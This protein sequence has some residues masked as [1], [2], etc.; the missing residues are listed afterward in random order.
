MLFLKY[1]ISKIIICYIL[2]PS[3][4]IKII[5]NTIVH[6]HFYVYENDIE[7]VIFQIFF[8]RFHIF[9]L[10]IIASWA[11]PIIRPGCTIGAIAT[12]YL[13]VAVSIFF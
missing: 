3:K 10:F 11:S 9:F 2:Y 1:K 8:R 4:F 5:S 13:V 6:I 7:S 12:Q